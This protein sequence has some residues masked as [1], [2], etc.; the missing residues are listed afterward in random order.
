MKSFG[1]FFLSTVFCA[2]AFPFVP[3]AQMD[4]LFI[5]GDNEYG[6]VTGWDHRYPGVPSWVPETV[7]QETF[8]RKYVELG[9][10][11]RYTLVEIDG[12]G[13]VNRIFFTLVL[14]IYWDDE[15]NPSVLSPVGD[16]FGAPFGRYK[17]YDSQPMGM[18]GGGFVCRFPMPFRKRAM[19]EIENGWDRKA[20]LVFFGINWYRVPDLPDDVLYFHALWRRTN[21]TIE[22]E[23]HVVAEIKGRG[24]FAGVQLFLQNRSEFLFKDIFTLMQPEGFGMGNLE[25]WEEIF[26]DGEFVQHGTGTEEYFNAGAYFSHSP[27]SGIYEGVHIRSY[28]T[29]RTSAYRFHVLDP[30]PFRDEFRMI[31]HHGL[32]DS[33]R[34][35]YASIAYWYQDEPHVPHSI[36]CL[37]ERLPSGTGEHVMQALILSPLVFGNK[38]LNDV[39]FE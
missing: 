22:G 9:A 27:Y 17:V 33:I 32:L 16:F 37:E 8:N 3:G 4:R 1:L 21:P 7:W 2:L 28:L 25:G 12:P 31:W 30:I 14:R 38:L 36:P 35:D 18:Q 20:D 15:D 23:P 19:I 39:M 26:I 13:I 6:S 5:P 29:G 24:N 10:G 11:E 34:S